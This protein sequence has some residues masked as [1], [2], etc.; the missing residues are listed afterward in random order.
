MS[1]PTRSANA[2]LFRLMSVAI[3]L[4]FLDFASFTWRSPDIPQPATKTVWSLPHPGKPLRPDNACK[5]LDEGALVVGQGLGQKIGALIH[6]GLRDEDIFGKTARQPD[7]YLR[8]LGIM[9]AFAV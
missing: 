7:L 8:A 3:T 5:R 9:P 1:D 2:S 4:H 6:Q